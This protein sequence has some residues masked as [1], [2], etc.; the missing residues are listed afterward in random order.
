MDRVEAG[1]QLLVTRDGRPVA[2]LRP[3]RRP[4]LRAEALLTRW[5]RLKPVD[6]EAF[7]ADI[8]RVLDQRL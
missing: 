7:R 1:E 5:R 4:G 6:P 3:V 2:Q 8:D